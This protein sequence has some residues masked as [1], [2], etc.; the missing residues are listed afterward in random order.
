VTPA[1]TTLRAGDDWT[2]AELAACVRMYLEMLA[3]QSAG[4]SFTKADKHRALVEGPLRNRSIK[5][6]E[7]R[8]R[9]ISAVLAEHH[10]KVVSG[11][12]PATN[13][14]ARVSERIESALTDAGY[15]GF[16]R[17]PTADDAELHRKAKSLMSVL[18]KNPPPGISEPTRK[19]VERYAYFRDPAVRAYVL[20]EANG[21]CELCKS[22]APFAMGDGTPFLEQHHVRP[23]SEGGS[24]TVGN[25]VALCPNCHRRCHHDA[26]TE[27]VRAALLDGIA[28]LRTE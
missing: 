26:N 19:V 21:A 5:A 25:S 28:R 1:E 2:D 15:F 23:L 13:V 24:D 14:G 16:L 9:N 27:A 18:A 7:Y 11:Y 8:M 12:I 3:L 22:P 6:V 17:R 20:R 4:R 10:E